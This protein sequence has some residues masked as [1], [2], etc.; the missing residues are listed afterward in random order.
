MSKHEAVQLDGHWVCQ[1]K[2]CP[3]RIASG[4]C[5]LGKVSL[6]C[7]NTDCW[8]NIEVAIG[9]YRCRCM[10]IHLDTDG[11]CLGVKSK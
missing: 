9:D 4:G 6:S 1:A 2:R 7:K 10:D 8:W 3:H 11:K 5:K